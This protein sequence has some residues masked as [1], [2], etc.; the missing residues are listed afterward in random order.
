MKYHL[1][2]IPVWDAYHENSECPLCILEDKAEKSYVD[3][4]LGGS[5][6]EPDT[7]IEVNEKGFCPHHNKLLYKAQNRL[8]L[9][10]MTHTH[11]LETMKK[12][13]HEINKLEKAAKN[14]EKASRHLMAK[15]SGGESSIEHAMREFS[16]WLNNHRN[17]CIICDRIEYSLNRYAY[18]IIHLWEHDQE[19]RKAMNQSKGF[20]FS[21]LPVVL[22]MAAERLSRSRQAELIS[23]LN[24][25]LLDNMDR[26]EK[27]LLWFTQKFDYKN[28]DKPWGNSRD[29][30]PR[31][32][33]KL[34]GKYME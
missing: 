20:C 24:K 2:T 34:T 10:L 30:L 19:F 11:T 8:G 7:R 33:Q 5:V 18:T 22:N 27:E 4:F 23:E 6:M 15:L 31:I 13:K 17:R 29:A 25:L 16:A 26:L 21:H 1:D 32:L 3:S 12:L 28:Q 14:P 9:A